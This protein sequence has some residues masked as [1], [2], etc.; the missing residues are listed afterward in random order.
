MT[1]K[2]IKFNKQVVTAKDLVEEMSKENPEEILA[3]AYKDG[4]FEVYSIGFVDKT[5]MLGALELIKY[6]LLLGE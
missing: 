4:Y 1:A 6:E 3:I 5:R 2:I